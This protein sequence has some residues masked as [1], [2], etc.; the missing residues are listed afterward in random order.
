MKVNV[1]AS[2]KPVVGM[3]VASTSDMSI[4]GII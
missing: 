2:E 1:F 4:T 3:K